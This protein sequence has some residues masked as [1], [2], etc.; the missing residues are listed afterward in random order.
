MVTRRNAY[1]GGNAIATEAYAAQGVPLVHEP[2]HVIPSEITF[3]EIYK[4]V[5]RQSITAERPVKHIMLYVLLYDQQALY[6]WKGDTRPISELKPAMQLKLR[7]LAMKTEG[8]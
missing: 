5:K 1:R 2:V 7:R 8:W 3:G 4:R 6:A